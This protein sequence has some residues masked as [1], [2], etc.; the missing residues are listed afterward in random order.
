MSLEVDKGWWNKEL[1][2]GLC[3][4][5]SKNARQHTSRGVPRLYSTPT[6]WGLKNYCNRALQSAVIRAKWGSSNCH[7]RPLQGA[8][9]ADL[10][11]ASPSRIANSTNE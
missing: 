2:Q 10:P 4:K 11:S 1:F 9:H 3:C 6:S 5:T 8:T 7:G